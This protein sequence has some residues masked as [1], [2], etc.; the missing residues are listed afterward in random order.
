MQRNASN[1]NNKLHII[2]FFVLHTFECLEDFWH[3]LIYCFTLHLT[4]LCDYIHIWLGGCSLYLSLC[5]FYLHADTFQSGGDGDGDVGWPV[6][7]PIKPEKTVRP[8]TALSQ[9]QLH[10]L[11]AYYKT[12]PRPDAIMKEQ[13]MELT[14]LSSRVI[15]VW[16]QNKRCKD[17]KKS[18]LGRQT[19]N[20]SGEQVGQCRRCTDFLFFN[21]S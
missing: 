10:V 3:L 5:I 16:F 12:N 18:M 8:R 21:D 13:L 20:E 7:E 11:L 9:S 15:R 6:L 1:M 17:K 19:Q 4:V 14:G 2:Q